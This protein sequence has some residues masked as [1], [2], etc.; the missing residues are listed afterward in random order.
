MPEAIAFAKQLYDSS[1]P[2]DRLGQPKYAY[3]YSAAG[4]KFI[5]H[6][7]SAAAL[8]EKFNRGVGQY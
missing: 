6:P 2:A 8:Q 1:R 7:Q 5:Q 3:T 4:G